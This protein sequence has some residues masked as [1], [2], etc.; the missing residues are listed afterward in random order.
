MLAHKSMLFSERLHPEADSAKQWIALQKSYGRTGR[1][2]VP[3]G[4][5]IGTSQEDQQSQLTWTLWVSQ[6]LNHQPKNIHRLY[7]DLQAH[8]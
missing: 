4:I 6:N 2:Q 5:K 8:M 1:M 3:R 7:R